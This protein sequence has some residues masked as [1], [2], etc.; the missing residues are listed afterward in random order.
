MANEI[1]WSHSAQRQ[2][3]EILLFWKD[4]NQSA[5]YCRTLNGLLTQ[6]I[7]LISRFPNIGRRTNVSGVRIKLL[8]DYYIIYEQRQEQIHILGVWDSRQDP[9]KLETM[10]K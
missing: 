2:W 6:S 1:V 10:L 3:K 8:R 4:H 7:D 9:V 5:A